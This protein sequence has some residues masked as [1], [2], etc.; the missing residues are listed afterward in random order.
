[1]SKELTAFEALAEAQE[2]SCLPFKFQA[3]ASLVD[4]GVLDAL[5]RAGDRGCSEEEIKASTHL[6]AYAMDVLLASALSFGLVRKDAGRYYATKVSFFLL[7]DPMARVNMNF[8][9]HVCYL[10]LSELSASLTEGRPAG[11]KYV[12]E[13]ETIYPHLKDLEPTVKKS[14]FEFDHFYSDNAFN[15]A[16]REVLKLHP[17]T[18]S[19]IGGNTGKF[20]TLCC[21]KDPDIK[22]RVLD[23][24]PQCRTVEENAKK[25]GFE[26]RI[27][28]YEI[29][30]LS[31]DPLPEIESDIWWM[32][33]FLDCFSPEQVVSILKKV[34]ARLRAGDRIA[35]LEIFLDTQ[36]HRVATECLAAFSLYFTVM[37]NGTSRFYSLEQ[38]EKLITEAG[39]VIERRADALGLG[40]TLLICRK[41]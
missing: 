22:V 34:K 1:M 30:A 2:I 11:L 3:A 36:K 10:G 5:D 15:E 4:L 29:D 40:H 24:P 16:L 35:I 9:R 38:F 33:Q 27:S 25:K 14:W 41:E 23:L 21:S 20:A 28:T 39:L 17:K 13:G 12:A 32:S 7:N 19:D 37:A 6:S 26:D 31:P 18:L 8:A